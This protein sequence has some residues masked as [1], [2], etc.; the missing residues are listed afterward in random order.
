MAA[1]Y[2]DINYI[3]NFTGAIL[4]LM[5]NRSNK[6]IEAI[7]SSSLWIVRTGIKS[8]WMATGAAVQTWLVYPKLFALA[9]DKVICSFAVNLLILI[10]D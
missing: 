5:W 6:Q 8:I 4:S 3:Q 2:S 10:F 1:P 9:D 7:P